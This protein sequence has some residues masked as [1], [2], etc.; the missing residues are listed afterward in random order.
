MA[1]IVT[2]NTRPQ[3]CTVRYKV[4]NAPEYLN[5]ASG[6]IE[7]MEIEKDKL[8]SAIEVLE[9]IKKEKAIDISEAETIIAVGRGVKSEKDLAMINILA[10]K[11][12]ATLACTR[13]GIETGWFDA[14]LQIGL[15]GR[16]VKPKLIIALGISG[17]V[18]FAAGMQNSEYIIA[19]NNDPQAPIFNIA[20]CGMV[21][22]L[23]D[24]LPEL[25]KMFDEKQAI[26]K[27]MTI[28]KISERMVG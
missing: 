14:R 28:P 1:Q 12:G 16:T 25:L 5:K 4:F 15:S 3:F 20:H 8:I 27:T 26:K 18:Q 7:I 17:A 11:I 23:Y 21:G 24:L 10:E 6:K 19:I 2:E 13:P 9:V 22:D